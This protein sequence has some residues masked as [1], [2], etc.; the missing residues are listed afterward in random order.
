MAK[1][2]SKSDAGEATMAVRSNGYRITQ[3]RSLLLELIERATGHLD[4]DELHRLARQHDERIS[5]STVYRT[6]SLL[7]RLGLVD[8]LHLSE[9]HHHYEAKS[10]AEHYH[11]V[12]LK[13]GRVIE[14]R[15]SLAER[16]QRAVC[17]RDGF[18]ATSTRI[19]ISGYCRSCQE[20]EITD[21]AAS[22]PNSL[23]SAP[24]TGGA[25]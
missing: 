12:C 4:A 17:K 6:L 19:D 14:F 11:L 24:T 5:L 8:E 9:D 2:K 23:A 10:N 20:P 25:S 16:L 1:S 18:V 3:Q 21:E 7:K 13:C 15:S 22:R